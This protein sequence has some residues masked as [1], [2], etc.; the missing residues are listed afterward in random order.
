MTSPDNPQEP[1]HRETVA[2]PVATAPIAPPVHDTPTSEPAAGPGRA[3][4]AAALLAGSVALANKLRR[5]VPRKVQEIRQQ[6]VAGRC[7]IL[8]ELDGHEVAI[9]PYP[10]NQA[11]IKDT[12]HVTGAPQVVE[13]IARTAYFAPPDDQENKP[14]SA[15]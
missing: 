5:E 10:N 1:T 4:K 6:R 3:V 15:S 13:L 8:T 7:V 2:A 9:G 12:V 14:G 11:A